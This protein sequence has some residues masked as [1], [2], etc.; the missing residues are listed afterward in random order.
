MKFYFYYYYNL[1]GIKII[2]AFIN[3]NSKNYVYKKYGYLYYEFNLY[4][5]LD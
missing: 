4:Y 3:Y 1:F 2:C 5:H